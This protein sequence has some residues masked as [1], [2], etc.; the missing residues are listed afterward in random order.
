ML[1]NPF[2]L[3]TDEPFKAYKGSYFT[4][5]MQWKSDDVVVDI[6]GYEFQAMF[7]EKYKSDDP[8][9]TIGTDEGGIDIVDAANG[10]IK[11]SLEIAQTALFNVPLNTTVASDIPYKDFPF[12]IDAIPPDT[13][14]RFQF[15]KGV[16]RV[17]GE[18]TR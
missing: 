8:I 7:R 13:T 2:I 11:I 10:I 4:K 18:V 1:E 16:I 5:T 15:L 17:Y 14:K 3:S 12:D 9:V 6:T